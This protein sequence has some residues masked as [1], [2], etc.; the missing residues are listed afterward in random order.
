MKYKVLAFT[1][2]AVLIAVGVVALARLGDQQEETTTTPLQQP[3]TTTESSPVV[4]TT[5]I[6]PPTTLLVA[7]EDVV[8]LTQGT[9]ST[10]TAPATTTTLVDVSGLQQQLSA[11]TADLDSAQ[12]TITRLETEAG[13]AAGRIETLTREGDTARRDAANYLQEWETAAGLAASRQQELTKVRA[14]RDN[15]ARELASLQT[16]A[17]GQLTTPEQ[18]L[19]SLTHTTLTSTAQPAI[20]AARAAEDEANKVPA[21]ASTIVRAHATLKEIAGRF[22]GTVGSGTNFL[23]GVTGN[24]DASRLAFGAAA[25]ISQIFIPQHLPR[26][27]EAGA[28]RT[29]IENTKAAAAGVLNQAAALLSSAQQHARNANHPTADRALLQAQRTLAKATERLNGGQYVQSALILADEALYTIYPKLVA[30]KASILADFAAATDA[31]F[32][33]R[34]TPASE[35]NTTPTWR[36]SSSSRDPISQA[37]LCAQAGF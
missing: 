29:E 12:S 28:L 33:C 9:T 2:I 16:L 5:P 13:A 17:R 4:T 30:D 11:L 35:R 6:E 10:T 8:I 15:A 27:A 36:S 22:S 3:T 37:V 23:N 7:T 14:E 20:N 18:A 31:K 1:A 19:A 21:L 26:F 25:H 24:R 32:D 34:N